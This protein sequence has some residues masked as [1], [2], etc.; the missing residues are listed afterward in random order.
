MDFLFRNIA[1]KIIALIFA[2]AMWFFVVGEKGSEVGFLIPLELKGMPSDLM[3]INEIKSHVDVRIFGPKTLLAG[4]SPAQM[5]IILD[6]SNSKAGNN[7]FPIFPKD[8]KA[9]RGLTVTR[10]SP[11]NI[12]VTLEPLITMTVPI[13]VRLTGK[14]QKGFKLGEVN[15]N[16]P[17][18][19]ITGASKE[20][21]N[22]I[23]ISTQPIDIDGKN[24][25]IEEVVLLDLSKLNLIKIDSETVAVKINILK[26]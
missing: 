13:K 25:E 23:A 12:K 1:L 8:V 21:K 18:V 9:P 11:T 22:L 26:K 3:I 4:L 5:G 10:V 14:P 6:L 2:I 16:P 20:I 15:V 19:Q 17:E 24:N 7:V